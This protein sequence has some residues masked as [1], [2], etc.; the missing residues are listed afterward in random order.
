[1]HGAV[2]RVAFGGLMLGL[3]A[4]APAEAGQTPAPA[5]VA[6]EAESRFFR[7]RIAD[8]VALAHNQ[9]YASADRAFGELIAQPEFARLN[10]AQRLQALT[11]AAASAV[12]LNDLP[13]AAGLYRQANA[14]DPN[15]PDG[16]YRLSAIEFNLHRHNE[17]ARAFIHLV[18]YWPELLPNIDEQMIFQ[19]VNRLDRESET[20]FGL[21]RALYDANWHSLTGDDGELWFV[22]LERHV[23]R[24]EHE[25]ARGVVRRIADPLSL[26]RL[27]SDKRFDFLVEADSWAFNVEHAAIGMVESLREK[28]DATPRGLEIR[29]QLISAMLVAGMHREALALTEQIAARIA[30]APDGQP[31]FDDIRQQSWV[32]N[33]RAI[34]LRRLGRIDEA[35]A[36]MTRASRLTEDGLPN[37]SQS[38]NLATLYCGL[39]RPDDSL[40]ELQRTG[41][42]LAGYGRMV[43]QANKLCAALAKRD[44][45]GVAAALHYLRE[46]RQDG[47]LVYLESLLRAQRIDDAAR[48]AAELLASTAD[49]ADALEW[50]QQFQTV[51]PLPGDVAY[52]QARETMLARADVQAAVA[53]VGR[54]GRYQV[55]MG[56]GT[57]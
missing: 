50:M 36:E 12:K 31:A 14:A 10:A 15:D 9:H 33:E 26:V 11:A 32:L 29:V 44:R 23:E 21:V 57:E 48:L 19:L 28:A 22:L 1:M 2:L 17:S 35:V 46:H 52:R 41:P 40:A 34:A 53:E 55:Y 6:D 18:E 20:R 4:T 51:E 27:R 56:S 54:I 8:A 13:R 39:D 37:V 3:C 30:E 42:D 38:L 45:D 25:A 43:M 49:R 47:P 7:Q 16:W 5:I 24:G